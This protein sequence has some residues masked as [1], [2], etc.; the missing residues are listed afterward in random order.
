MKI[1]V[2]SKTVSSLGRV[3]PLLRDTFSFQANA[4]VQVTEKENIS[5]F[6]DF[7]FIRSCS[8]I[9]KRHVFISGPCKDTSDRE[10]KYCAS[11]KKEGFCEAYHI[12]MKHICRKTCDFCK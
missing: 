1:S 7:L 11:W 3:V 10:G 9:F 12:D 2:N 5:P 6:T 4:N 8:T